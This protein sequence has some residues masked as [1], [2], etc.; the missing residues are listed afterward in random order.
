MK[1][2]VDEESLKDNAESNYKTMMEVKKAMK[3]SGMSD[4]DI[5]RSL[6]VSAYCLGAKRTVEMV[7]EQDS[8]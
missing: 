1:F 2:K 5:E 6:I 4:N 3:S 7:N 8:N